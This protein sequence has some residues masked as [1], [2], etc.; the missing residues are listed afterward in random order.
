MLR[1]ELL[2]LED[3][4]L[5]MARDRESASEAA[6]SRMWLDLPGTLLRQLR[7]D[8]AVQVDL[9]RI[10]RSDERVVQLRTKDGNLQELFCEGVEFVS[11]SKL[12]FDLEMERQQPGWLVRRFR[13]SL[14]LIDRPVKMVRIHLN[15]EVGH[16]PVKVA[17]CHL[18]I[19]NSN[20]HIPFP[21]MNPRLLVHFI[22][23]HI[24]PHL[25]IDQ[26]SAV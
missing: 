25:G 8:L 10:K 26:E 21:I 23:E 20:P 12:A 24:E 22:C 11:E 1:E 19:D 17:R 9:H 15:G 2:S 5:Q 7:N 14:H 4:L 18:H 6:L 3:E 13:F 16:D